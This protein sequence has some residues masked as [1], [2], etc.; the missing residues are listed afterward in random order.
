MLDYEP[1]ANRGKELEASSRLVQ[2]LE[3][4]WGKRWVDVVLLDGLYVSQSHI[5]QHL[6]AGLDVLIKTDETRLNIIEDAEGIF[7][8]WEEFKDSVSYEKGVDEERLV[9]YEIWSGSDFKLAGV[10]VPFKVARVKERKLKTGKEV[11]FW[12]LTTRVSLSNVQMRELAHRRW[13]IENNGFKQL[14]DEV[15]SKHIWTH[16]EEVWWRLFWIQMMAANL[17][18]LFEG[19]LEKKGVKVARLTREYLSW[20]LLCSLIREVTREELVFN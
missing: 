7:N 1:M 6:R 19:W 16:D 20:L 18:G 8:R 17:M 12:V 9:A 4:H 11:T 15:N 2:R 3:K 13:N 14:N 10:A 5:N